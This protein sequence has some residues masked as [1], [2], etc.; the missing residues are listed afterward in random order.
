M[1]EKISF[2]AVKSKETVVKKLSLKSLLKDK[3]FLKLMEKSFF[4]DYESKVG[5]FFEFR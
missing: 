1:Y 2:L 5:S 3:L 4:K